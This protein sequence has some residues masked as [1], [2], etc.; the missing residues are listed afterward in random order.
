MHDFFMVLDWDALE[1][2]EV[3]P[4]YVPEAHAD[5]RH[6]FPSTLTN[7]D[8][9]AEA[10]LFAT[11]AAGAAPPAHAD[12]PEQA[13]AWSGFDFNCEDA[14][15]EEPEPEESEPEPEP[16]GE[17]PAAPEPEPEPEPEEEGAPMA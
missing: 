10:E 9:A 12:T 11:P 1:R 13:A 5:T 17:P 6:H 4:P 3:A 7:K 2:K 16:A 14:I 8:A 15:A